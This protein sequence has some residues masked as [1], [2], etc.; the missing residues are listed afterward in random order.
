MRSTSYL[1]VALVT[2]LLSV[3]Y[4]A[5]AFGLFIFFGLWVNVIYPLVLIL[6]VYF[7]VT[8]YNQLSVAIER[9][10]LLKLATRDSL[11]GLFNIGHF[12]LLLKAEISTISLRREKNLS[13]IMGD[14][15]NFKNTN[16]TYG[17]VTGDTV[18]KEVA[19]IVKNSCRA[20]DVAARYGGEEFIL[21]LPGASV[22]EAFKVAEK[23]RIAVNSKLF[24]HQKGD[25]QTSI[26]IGVTQV[27]PDEKDIEAVVARAD[28]ALY[29]AKH[30]GKNKVMIATDSPKFDAAQP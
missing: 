30:S 14:V 19:G 25:F 29:E 11:T 9:A 12:K 8:V 26:S 1:R 28:R 18:L 3:G 24:F 4:V 21:M 5:I 6:T 10:K 15:D 13:L 2:A 17:H 16:D 27:S 23:I 7:V 20:L 22:D